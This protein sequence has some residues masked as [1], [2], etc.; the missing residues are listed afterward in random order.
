MTAVAPGARV[1][2]DECKAKGYHIAATVVLPAEAKQVEKSLRRLLKPGQRRIHFNQESDS[3]RRLL[4]SRMAELGVRVLI[5]T[6]RGE[7]ERIARGACLDA[8]VDDLVAGR[9]HSLILERHPPIEPYDRRVIR[10]AL[11]RNS[12]YELAYRHADPGEHA[13]LWVSD[14]LAWCCNAGGEWKRRAGPMIAA[15]R[16]L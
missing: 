7:G 8:L 14:A 13:L 9:A 1:F 5:Y 12:R 11:L 15:H 3:R 6:V 4:L 16:V 10:E 2:V